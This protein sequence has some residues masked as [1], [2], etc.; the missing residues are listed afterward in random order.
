MC[1]HIGVC[2]PRALRETNV[3]LTSMT[4]RTM[5]VKITLRVWMELTLT[6]VSAHLSTQV[7]H[8]HT[9][10]L[11]DQA[12]KLM[13]LFVIILLEH[14]H[15]KC[16]IPENHIISKKKIVCIRNSAPE[17]VNLHVRRLTNVNLN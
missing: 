7:T 13:D 3:R 4:A 17:C 6:P 14:L 1:T 9:L 11:I 12:G 10:G 2:V 16:G 8:T 15:K 5:T